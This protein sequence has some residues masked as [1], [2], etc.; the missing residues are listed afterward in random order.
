MMMRSRPAQVRMFAGVEEN[1]VTIK[2][3]RFVF[4]ISVAVTAPPGGAANRIPAA[5][6]PGSA[7][8]PG[9]ARQEG[10]SGPAIIA[11]VFSRNKV[12]DPAGIAA[13]KLTHINYAFANIAGGKIIEGFANDAKN[14]E[15]LS[16]LRA[17]HPHLKI[18]ISVGGWTWSGGFS[19]M[20]LTSESRGRFVDSAV[21]FVRRHNLDGVDIDWEYPGLPGIGNPYRPEDKQNFTALM[22][23][24]RAALDKEGEA[25]KRR[26]W[27]TFAAGA[28]V[29]ECLDHIE[30]NKVQAVVDFVNLMTYDFREAESDSLAGHHSNL[31]GNPADDKKLSADRA[32]RDYLA[33]GV[34][35]AK[36]VVGVPFYGHVW[37]EVKPVGNGLYQPGKPPQERIDASYGNLVAQLI[38]KNGYV[39]FWDKKSQ[40]P[41]L[42]N[43][44]KRVFIS[45]EDPESLRLKCGYI[46]GH[47]LGGVM[48]WEYYADPTGSLLDI[49]YKSLR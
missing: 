14:F 32:V 2:L 36:V 13:G 37:A 38:G 21:K 6:I 33:A 43:A 42:W 18:L 47:K 12:I 26:Y 28:N 5:G 41:Y 19:D 10:K 49:L 40:A 27:L 9:A 11:Y 1:A 35:P 20:A 7:K 3:A 44:S 25:Q 34:P 16:G 22:A 4:M 8:A 30:I 17:G 39:R 31:Y 24:L 29:P 46:R 45:Y 23:E 48:F 15:V